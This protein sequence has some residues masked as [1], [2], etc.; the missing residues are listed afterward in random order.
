VIGNWL[1][2]VGGFAIIVLGVLIGV[3]VVAPPTEAH[4]AGTAFMA[5]GLA[6]LLLV[7]GYGR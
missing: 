3:G 6:L 2:A 4:I 1:M 7:A 5:F